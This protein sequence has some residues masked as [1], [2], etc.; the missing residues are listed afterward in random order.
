MRKP[1]SLRQNR[2]DR[3]DLI[4]G[5]KSPGKAVGFAIIVAAGT[6]LTPSNGWTAAAPKLDIAFVVAD[7]ADP[8]YLTMKC[9]AM[10]AAEEMNVNLSW[11]GSTSVDYAPEM[12]VLHAVELKKPEGIVLAPFSPIAFIAPVKALMAA[13][14][15]VVTVD[16]NLAEKVELENI[17]TNN[18][19]AGASAADMLGEALHGKG[20]VGVITF[21]PGIP[22]EVARVNGF[23]EEMHKK[24]PGVKV[25]PTQYGGADAGKSATITSGLLASHPDIA[26][27][28][29]T[30]TN[31]AEGAASAVR[32]AGD[33]AKVKVVAYDAAPEEVKALRSG[34]FT[35]LVAQEPYQE[36]YRAVTLLAKYL[37]HEITKKDIPYLYQTGAVVV[38]K[39]NVDSPTV[40]HTVLY[41]STCS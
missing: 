17:H 22:V 37:R 10:K 3:T 38:T 24:F 2:V 39:A 15:P 4:K 8:F 21:Q 29:A 11:Q 31:D 26:G 16:G 36:G 5:L 34:L 14:T 23:V 1:K 32:A 40:A 19:G 35:A 18:S 25:L 41:E 27:I 13:G 6:A 33:S 30:D 9:G 7:S 12:S 20:T 28:Y